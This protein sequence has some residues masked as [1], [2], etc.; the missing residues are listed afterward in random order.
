MIRGK[1]IC[2][3]LFFVRELKS[4]RNGDIVERFRRSRAIEELRLRKNVFI[5]SLR[6]IFSYIKRAARREFRI[7]IAPFIKI[8]YIF[9]TFRT[10][11][12]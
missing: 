7:S 3:R 12:V 5:V 4:S 10:N 6:S 8:K 11:F 9:V 1:W 2:S